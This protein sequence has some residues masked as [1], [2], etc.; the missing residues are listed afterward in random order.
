MNKKDT[1]TDESLLSLRMPK[2]KTGQIRRCQEL[3]RLGR[4]VEAI[5]N[6]TKCFF[7]DWVA[8]NN[9]FASKRDLAMSKIINF[10]FLFSQIS[11]GKSR[12]GR[13]NQYC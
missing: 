13:L 7:I 11:V 9:S 10:L 2:L 5:R 6:P 4:Y 1:D 12:L 3:E 8:K